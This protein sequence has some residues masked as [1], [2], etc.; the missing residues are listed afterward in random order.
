MHVLVTGGAGYIGSHT[1]VT[2][3]ERGHR[4]TIADNFD[5]SSPVVVDRIERITGTRPTI[6]A[7]DLLNKEALTNVFAAD[8]PDAVIH[9]AGLKAVGESVA[10]PLRYYA[11]NIGTTLNLVD[12][13]REHNVHRLVFSSSATVYGDEQQP[14]YSEDGGHLNATNPYGQTK[15]MIERILAD[16]AH[17]E[18]DWSIGIL[19]YFNPVGAHES[20]LIGEDPHGIPNNLTPYILQV[21]VGRLNELGIFGNDYPTA[22]GTGERDYIHVVDLAEGHVAAL[23]KLA[24]TTGAH[25]WNLGT[26]TP[27]SVLDVVAAFEKAIGKP[28]PYSIK[29]RRAGDLP[30]SWADTTRAEQEL[31]WKATRDITA[32]ARD[33]WRWQSENPDGY[34][35]A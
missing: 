24:T 17:A 10:Q 23:E 29:P 21:A 5:N 18:P 28:I 12:V 25:A 11:T 3:I 31:G 8:T 15:V 20:G 4:V 35:G 19:R 13:M 9:F 7:V 32:M 2:L 33:G 26:G 6:A 30:Q 34:A 27:T 1:A 16:L 14:P 22:D